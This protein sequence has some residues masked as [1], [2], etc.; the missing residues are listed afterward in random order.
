MGSDFPLPALSQLSPEQRA[1]V[2]S[3]LRTRPSLDGPFLPWLHRPGLASTAERLGA[4][5]R[6]DTLL[7]RQDSELAILCVAALTTCEGEKRIHG[8]IAIQAGLPSELVEQ[9]LAGVAPKPL[10]PRLSLI[11]AVCRE[12][13]IQFR[14]SESTQENALLVF[15]AP[16]L[17]EL[18]A[19]VGYYMLVAMTL[20]VFTPTG[21]VSGT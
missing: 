21:S 12:L 6:F 11:T 18:V 4:Y 13:A 16:A 17:V 2:T 7:S 1:V 15:G 19:L 20:N 8:P 10:N 14:L 3:I 9:L 5:L